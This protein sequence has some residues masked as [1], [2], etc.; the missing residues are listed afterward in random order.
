MKPPALL[1]HWYSRWLDRRIPPA[2]EVVL[3][4]K[5]IFILPTGYGLFFVAIAGALFI[6]GINY[7]N[8]L[9]IGL[10]F[11]MASLFVI[12]ILHTY[13]NLAG[14]GLAAGASESG[15]AGAEGA[16]EVLI[17][18]ADRHAHRSLVLRWPG[19]RSVQVSVEP[20]EE[21]SSWLKIP[22]PRRGRVNPGRLQVETRYPLGLLRAWSLVDLAHHCLAW[23]RPLPGGECPS[24][25][26]NER[27][28]T[29]R[30]VHGSDDFQGLRGYREGDSPRLIDWKALARTG[31]LQTKY[32]ADPAQ[33]WL[34]L[35][36]DR[37][38]GQDE[39]TRLSRLCWWVLEMERL[40]RLYGLRLPN[41]ELPPAQGTE[42]RRLA[43]DMLAGFGAH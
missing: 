33:G 34:W 11:L 10:A 15:F 26:G 24:G 40:N 13:R 16:L 21:L 29:A 39:E 36:W 2:R 30:L 17:H 37:L 28:G 19:G 9:I 18:A 38:A 7:E 43:L 12:A 6:G 8:N 27:E 3:N 25:G 35:E 14:L 23:P 1:R 22:L 41:A 42:Q 31:T 4:Q 32:F 5:R 20:G